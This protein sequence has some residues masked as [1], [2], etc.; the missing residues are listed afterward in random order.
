MLSTREANILQPYFLVVVLPEAGVILRIGVMFA[1]FVDFSKS[2]FFGLA[3]TDRWHGGYPRVS[4]S[5]S[6]SRPD[7]PEVDPKPTD[8]RKHGGPWL[9]E[10]VQEL[11]IAAQEWLIFYIWIISLMTM[12]AFVNVNIM[13]LGSVYWDYAMTIRLE[14]IVYLH[15]HQQ[16]TV[17]FIKGYLEIVVT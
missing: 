9:W 12:T 14:E 10:K 4:V 15:C 7:D 6:D 2:P 11:K 16:G 1:H 13:F 5:A 8:E 17:D 3:M